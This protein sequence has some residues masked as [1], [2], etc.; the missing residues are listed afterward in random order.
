VATRFVV[1]GFAVAPAE[2]LQACRNTVLPS[3]SVCSLKTLPAGFRANSLASFDE[4]IS[5]CVS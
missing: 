1:T 2:S 5:V 3:S 4:M